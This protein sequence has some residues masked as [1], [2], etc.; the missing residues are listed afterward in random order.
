MQKFNEHYETIT[1]FK[2]HDGLIL[3]S[4]FTKFEDKS[5]LV[6]GGNDNTVVIWE[7]KDCVE[8]DTVA[9]RTNNGM[10]VLKCLHPL[11]SH[12]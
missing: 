11:N 7:V 5:L 8:P 2:A 6:T 1:T 12:R 4:A 10:L 3:A 9:R